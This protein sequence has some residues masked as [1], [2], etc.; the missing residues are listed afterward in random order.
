MAREIHYSFSDKKLFLSAHD[1]SIRLCLEFGILEFS[2]GI[3]IGIL[4]S[5]KLETEGRILFCLFAKVGKCCQVNAVFPHV[6]HLIL[7]RRRGRR[8]HFQKS[9]ASDGSGWSEGMPLLGYG[10]TSSGRRL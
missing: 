4:E 7:R 1:D 2:I 8:T 5:G 9:H 6:S 10:G 3:L